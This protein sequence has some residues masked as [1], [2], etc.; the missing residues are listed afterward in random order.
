[1]AK[2]LV[3][4][5]LNAPS[6]SVTASVNDTFAF[7][8]TPT[9]SGG[10]GTQRY[11]FKWEVN[12]GGGYVTIA[13]SGTGLTTSGTNPIINTNSTAAQSIT[14][15]CAEAGSYTIRMAGAPTSGGSYTVFS[16]TQTVEVSAQAITGT[17]ALSAQSSTASGAGT[18]LST[19][20]GAL[21][22][23]GSSVNGAG[24]SASTGTGA[25]ASPASAVSGEG[26]VEEADTSITGTGALSG[27][28]ATL[29]GEGISLSTGTGAVSAA[30]ASISGSGRVSTGGTGSLSVAAATMSGA[31][32]VTGGIQ[33]RS[34]WGRSRLK[35]MIFLRKPGESGIRHLSR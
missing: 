19:G 10:G 27:A 26:T 5:T 12:D 24:T 20:S 35:K 1:V 33:V 8:G 31:G 2:V 22:A 4:I 23:Q 25:L 29:A 9:V 32:E 6:S 7:T 15:T 14:V 30:A 3:S 13:S 21:A 28:S 34:Y 11:D 17:G 18:S 16:T